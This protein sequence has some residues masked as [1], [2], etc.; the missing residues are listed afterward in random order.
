MFPIGCGRTSRPTA[1]SRSASPC[2]S[3][4]WTPGSSRDDAYA[5]RAEGGRRRV[6][7][8]GRLPR[9]PG[10]DPEV[11]ARP[12]SRG[13]RTRSSTR[14]V[15][16]Q[17]RRRLRRSSRS[18]PWRG[19]DAADGRDGRAAAQRQGPR[20]VR[21]RSR[22]A[23]AGRHRPHQRL[24]RG[25]ARR[26]SP[27]RAA[28]SPAVAVL[29]RSDRRPRREPPRD[30]GPAVPAAVRR[31]PGA[32]RRAPCSCAAPTSC[33]SS[34]SRA[35]TCRLGL[36]AV[37]AR[38]AP[39]AACRCRRASWSPTGCPSRS[40]RR[41]RRPPRATTCRSRPTE[42]ADLVGRGPRRTTEGAH[43]R[44]STSALRRIA[45]ERGII[46]ADTKF[47]FGFCDG[48]LILVDE[49]VHAGLVPVL[50]GGRVRAGRARSR[51]STS[52]TCATGSTRAG[53]DH[54]PPPPELPPEVVDA[55][56]ARYREAYERITGEPFDGY[57]RRMGRTAGRSWESTA[58]AVEVLVSLKPGCPTRRA[59][60]S[61]A[62]C[63][64]SAGRT[65]AT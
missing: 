10:S 39:C 38:P 65:S 47:E 43:A 18:S 6:G 49:V 51:A 21:R 17:P 44:P 23:A 20:P 30:G 41:R 7:P 8:R 31:R 34:A 1:A 55:T 50:A 61:R 5:H 42:A 19:P 29:V 54:E 58:F 37:P 46:L 3:R 9:R 56:A 13:A 48:E 57:L 32:G 40:S 60:P 59:R 16:A 35:A 63:R 28:C 64:R 45:L 4:S 27:T 11:A 62:R 24:R 12:Q 36:V 33:R 2:C 25:P 22:P 14:A 52:S 15:P 26:R 53:W